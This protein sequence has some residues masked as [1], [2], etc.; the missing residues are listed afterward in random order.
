MVFVSARTWNANRR[1]AGIRTLTGIMVLLC[2][3]SASAMGETPP[4][5]TG[6]ARP[7]FGKDPAPIEWKAPAPTP[8]V[9]P[10]QPTPQPGL[11]TETITAAGPG[12][13]NPSAR[14]LGV[15][16]A[17]AGFAAPTTDLL[18]LPSPG[19][20]D[21][22]SVE[23]K[24]NRSLQVGIQG[25]GAVV[26]G[27]LILAEPGQSLEFTM[28]LAGGEDAQAA[29]GASPAPVSRVAGRGRLAIRSNRQVMFDAAAG[30]IKSSAS[31]SVLWEA[32]QQ[33]GLYKL[34]LSVE[35]SFTGHWASGEEVKS[36]PVVGK[37]ELLVFVQYAFDRAGSGVIEGYPIGIY[38]NETAPNVPGIVQR[39]AEKYAP[40]KWFVKVTQETGRLQLSPHF[41]LGDFAS[42]G[43]T[44]KDHFIA[45]KPE[46]ITYLEEVWNA[47]VREY[48]PSA[49]VMILRAYLSPYEWQRLF[50]KGVIYTEYN[51]YQYGDGTALIVD[52]DGSG[53]LGDLNRDG[54]VDREDA[55]I[56][57]N[58]LEKVQDSL[59]LKGGL[60]VMDK[61]IEPDWPETPYVAADLRGERSR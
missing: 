19:V 47:A 40:P 27:C 60:L 12:L 33:P 17:P 51:R 16:P 34:G 14:A 11:T 37:Q 13:D 39:H 1:L 25:R 20:P 36:D 5:Q 38:P 41:R 49:R 57:A 3:N 30:L 54:K 52:L 18:A 53:R 28:E 35:E 50:K 22:K 48:G 55:T 23:S 10:A 32:P 43:E 4:R 15:S 8:E 21:L 46:L 24:A 45:V 7:A 44:G 42:P 29:P 31:S 2:V 61:P 6:Q 58:L 9:L 26:P 59:K 56:L